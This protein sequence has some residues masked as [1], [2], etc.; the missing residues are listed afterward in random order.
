MLDDLIRGFT[1]GSFLFRKFSFERVCCSPRARAHAFRVLITPRAGPGP[2][3]GLG[4]F[5]ALAV[6]ARRRQDRP[7][8][9]SPPRA[10]VEPA[11]RVASLLCFRFVKFSMPSAPDFETLFSQAQ[12]FISACNGE[13]IRYATDTCKRRRLS[14]LGGWVPLSSPFSLCGCCC[15]QSPGSATS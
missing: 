7:G 3:P 4:V 2:C 10:A 15:F 8:R 5:T 9:T 13:H 14:S 1:S 11:G 6:P 12:L